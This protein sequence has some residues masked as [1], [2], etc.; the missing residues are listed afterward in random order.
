MVARSAG[1]DHGQ[2]EGHEGACDGSL[3]YPERVN[4]TRWMLVSV[5]SIPLILRMRSKTLERSS[6]EAA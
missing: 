2:D 4:V 1:Q 6:V 5:L 3:D